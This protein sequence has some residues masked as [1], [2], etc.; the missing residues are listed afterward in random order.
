MEIKKSD[1]VEFL[2]EIKQFFGE[3]W[4]D[5]ECLKAGNIPDPIKAH[6]VIYSC[7]QVKKHLNENEKELGLLYRHDDALINVM[8]LGSYLRLLDNSMVVDLKGNILERTMKDVFQKRLRNSIHYK[9]AFYEIQVACLYIRGGYEVNFIDD[10]SKSPEF[11]VRFNG[12]KVY[13]ECKGVEKKRLDK[14]SGDVVR[15]LIKKYKNFL[16]EMKLGVLIVCPDK[17]YNPKNWIGKKVKQLIDLKR[18]PV[19]EECEGYI[20]RVFDPLLVE[21]FIGDNYNSHIRI[22]FQD[23]LIPFIDKQLKDYPVTYENIPIDS[24]DYKVVEKKLIYSCQFH[25]E[26]YFGVAF[27]SLPS[28]I[29]GVKNSI[30]KAT[31]QLPKDSNGIIYVEGPPDKSTDEEI[32]EFVR[33]INSALSNNSRINALVFTGVTRNDKGCEH[34][35]NVVINEKSGKQLPEGFKIMPLLDKFT[36]S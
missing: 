29:S 6:P 24:F 25:V 14:A 4:F 9:S 16:T 13:V 33:N 32:S 2:I 20:F 26:S 30:K 36:F 7:I 34:I 3:E 31:R 21:N 28:I 22:F 11:I 5:S 15:K 10:K 8:M 23:S 12:S 18:V 1:L 35:T 19:E 27:K 17:A